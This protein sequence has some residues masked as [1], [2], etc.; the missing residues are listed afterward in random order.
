MSD[1]L[2]WRGVVH[3][4]LRDMNTCVML[5]VSKTRVF[6]ASAGIAF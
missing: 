4:S 3:L 6:H 5:G 2:R 1:D